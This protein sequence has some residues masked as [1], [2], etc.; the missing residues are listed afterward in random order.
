MFR[1][2]LRSLL[3]S[4]TC[5]VF[6]I[7]FKSCMNYICVRII[8]VC[9]MF[10]Y[11]LFFYQAWVGDFGRGVVYEY[12]ENFKIMCV[13]LS[14]SRIVFCQYVPFSNLCIL[15]V[16]GYQLCITWVF[17]IF[18]ASVS[19]GLLNLWLKCKLFVYYVWVVDCKCILYMCV[20]NFLFVYF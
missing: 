7:L 18:I 13:C 15:C 16:T 19:F 17:R 5:V 8:S 3:V 20:Y 1:L 10:I 14:I 4:G 2:Y 9:I 11:R 12:G 6:V